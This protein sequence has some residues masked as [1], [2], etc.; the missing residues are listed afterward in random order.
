M[1]QSALLLVAEVG[2]LAEGLLA[3]ISAVPGIQLVGQSVTVSSIARHLGP[4]GP[5]KVLIDFAL[6]G[7]K[8]PAVIQ[9]VRAMSPTAKCIVLVDEVRQKRSALGAGA[10]VVLLKGCV[11][12]EIV[13]AI[14]T[15]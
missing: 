11:A 1:N 2:P 3:I 9:E 5:A 13:E 15:R 7:A 14:R 12:E 8:T 6:F 4:D 10:D